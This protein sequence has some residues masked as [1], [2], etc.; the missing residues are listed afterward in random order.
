[1]LD[2]N[3]QASSPESEGAGPWAS[4][5]GPRPTVPRKRGVLVVDDDQGVRAVVGAWL[6]HEGY[7]VWL[8][9]G[10]R[11]AIDIY[12]E[13]SAAID[14]V[15][16]DVNMPQIDGPETLAS[17]RDRDPGIGCCFMSADTGAYTE[18]GLRGLRAAFLRKPFRLTEFGRLLGELASPVDGD[19]A[20]QDDRRHDGR[21]S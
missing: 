6:R 10:G 14:V 7:A 5:Q 12:G 1:M 17:L 19:A 8:A 21:R 18:A 9:A 11:E 15:I 4:R 20:R 2:I 13:N 16:L 3:R